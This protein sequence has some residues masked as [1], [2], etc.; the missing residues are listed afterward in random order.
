MEIIS[1]GLT[2]IIIWIGSFMLKNFTKNYIEKNKLLDEKLFIIENFK[3]VYNDEEEYF[4][5]EFQLFNNS[6]FEINFLFLEFWIRVGDS[7]I[8]HEK[9]I[10][11]KIPKGKSET[12]K[13]YRNASNKEIQSVKSFLKTSN[14]VFGELDFNFED[15]FKETKVLNKKISPVILHVF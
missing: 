5:V 12:I 13:I 7:L 15:K 3:I 14:L 9:N 10:F 8:R 2:K 11:K 4:F 6:I 1:N